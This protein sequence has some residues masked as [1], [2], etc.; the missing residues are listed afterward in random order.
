MKTLGP[1]YHLNP[2]M[3]FN[4]NFLLQKQLQKSNIILTEQPVKRKK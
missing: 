1:I 2:K 3:S 4:E